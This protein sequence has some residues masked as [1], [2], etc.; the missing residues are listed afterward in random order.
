[1]SFKVGVG[2]S[3]FT[4]LRNEENYRDMSS[5]IRVYRLSSGIILRQSIERRLLRQKQK[6]QWMMMLR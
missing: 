6:M 1:M 3:D 5:M 2:K 4:S